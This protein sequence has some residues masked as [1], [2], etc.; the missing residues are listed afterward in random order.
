MHHLFLVPFAAL[1]FTSS[2]AQAEEHVPV[3]KLLSTSTTVSGQQITVPEHPTVQA[4]VLTIPPGVSLPVH[5]HPY[6]RYGYVQKGEIDVTLVDAKK[7]LHLK[8][9]EFFPEII[10]GWH[11]GTNNTKEPV[12]LLIID[13]VPEGVESNTVARE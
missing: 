7:V 8:Q 4:M 11:F 9:G 6:P 2:L 13:Q 3:K 10:D 1:L 5:K 12:E